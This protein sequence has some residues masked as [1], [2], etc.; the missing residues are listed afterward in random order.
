MKTI[1]Y[2]GSHPDDVETGCAGSI[3]KTTDKV[4]VVV[5]S[6]CDINTGLEIDS[7]QILRE[8]YNSMKVLRVKTQEVLYFEN[9]KFRQ[10]PDAIRHCIEKLRREVK[11]DV[12]Y[13]PAFDDLH[14][15][16]ATLAMEALRAFRRGKEE[17]RSY[18][19][20]STLRGFNPNIYVDITDVMDKKIEA[21][22]CYKSQN[23][24]SYHREDLF[25][26][27]AMTRGARIGVQYAEAFQLIR[28]CE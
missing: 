12:V 15:D 23:A 25:K 18:E 26:S 17:L 2:L 3:A 14:Q 22:M 1:L 11:P 24:R 7:G 5:F 13:M 27:I 6:P 28:R 19:A 20:G 10:T 16:H 9:T 8:F 21:L 4:V